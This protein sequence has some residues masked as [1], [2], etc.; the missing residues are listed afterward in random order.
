MAEQPTAAALV[1]ALAD[2]ARR[3]VFAA[4]QLGATTLDEVVATSGLTAAQAGKALGKLVDT[5]VVVGDGGLQVAGDVFQQAART[6]LARPANDEHADAS[7]AA[8]RVLQAFV[9]DGRLH[10]I[11]SAPAKRAVVLDWLAQAFEPGR[12]YSEQMVNLLL[13]QRHPDTAALRRYLVDGGF[14]DREGGQYWRSGGTVAPT[15]DA[16][17]TMVDDDVSTEDDM[18]TE[19]DD[20]AN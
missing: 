14:L 8:R 5:G 20:A 13:G 15:A 11:P 19:D 18:S 2:E 16:V 3:R 4:V 1:G 12:H 6:A 7:A 9:A 10:T 17:P